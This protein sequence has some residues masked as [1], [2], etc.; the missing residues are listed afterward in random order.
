LCRPRGDNAGVLFHSLKEFFPF[1]KF[2]QGTGPTTPSLAGFNRILVVVTARLPQKSIRSISK[3]FTIDD[4][5]GGADQ[6]G[7]G[8]YT[9]SERG[10]LKR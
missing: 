3:K 10:R 2:I 7:N 8:M 1:W 5:N 9:E 4:Q 6:Q